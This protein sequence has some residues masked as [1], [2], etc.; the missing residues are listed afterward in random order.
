MQTTEVTYTNLQRLF[1]KIQNDRKSLKR[2]KPT[3]VAG[4]RWKVERQI[5]LCQ[6][7]VVVGAL[8]MGIKA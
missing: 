6:G 8:M 5:E 7:F 2:F 1:K 4:A 3:C